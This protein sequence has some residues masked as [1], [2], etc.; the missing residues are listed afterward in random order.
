MTETEITIKF[1]ARVLS[2]EER[3]KKTYI[4]GV[5][6]DAQ[7]IDKSLGYFAVLEGSYEALYIGDSK[8]D[9]VIGSEAVVGV[10]FKLAPKTGQ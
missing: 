9:I 3:F 1:T 7:F 4:D 5:G 10:R 2:V 8:L 6:A